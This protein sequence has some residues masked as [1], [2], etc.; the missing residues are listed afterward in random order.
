MNRLT[1][2]KPST[3]EE[4]HETLRLLGLKPL[5]P[6][7][8]IRTGAK[9]KRRRYRPAPKRAAIL[10]S[11]VFRRDGYRCQVCDKQFQRPQ[12]AK[13]GVTGLTLGH[14]VEYRF[15]GP[16]ATANLRAECAE[17]NVE[18]SKAVKSGV[19]REQNIGYG[20]YAPMGA[21]S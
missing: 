20:A 8:Y 16:Y 4:A 19:P 17:C 5:E 13:D 7:L 21:L 2:S 6:P 3:I 1:F 15:G 18:A 11:K 9:H 14:V 10:R 12:N